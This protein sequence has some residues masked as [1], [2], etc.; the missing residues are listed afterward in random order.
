M[1]V[2][3]KCIW[4]LATPNWYVSKWVIMY[5]IFTL[6]TS[7][8]CSSTDLCWGEG[9]KKLSYRSLH[10]EARLWYCVRHHCVIQTTT[11]SSLSWFQWNIWSLLETDSVFITF[12]ASSLQLTRMQYVSIG[13]SCRAV[14]LLAFPRQE[15]FLLESC[16]TDIFL[17]YHNFQTENLI[18]NI[19]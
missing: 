13:K 10:T 12:I 15:A 14:I 3:G 8:D 6:N 16:Y 7:L 1:G 2:K 5:Q 9:G 11:N 18:A 4:I 19:T 17:W